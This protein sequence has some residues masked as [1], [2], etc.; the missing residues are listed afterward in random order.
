MSVGTTELQEYFKD[1]HP[2]SKINLKDK[3]YKH[4]Q[5]SQLDYR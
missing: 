5:E 1:G 4:Y 3:V 2:Y